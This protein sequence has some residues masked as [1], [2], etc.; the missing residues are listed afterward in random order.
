MIH[1]I[2]RF[3]SCTLDELIRV[4]SEEPKTK[5]LG[6]TKL[7]L[8]PAPEPEEPGPRCK[9]ICCKSVRRWWPSNP[10][11]WY[12]TTCK[13]VCRRAKGHR[14]L[15]SCLGTAHELYPDEDSIEMIRRITTL[16]YENGEVDHIADPPL[17]GGLPAWTKTK[18]W[19]GQTVFCFEEKPKLKTQKDSAELQQ[20]A[21][22]PDPAEEFN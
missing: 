16:T 12:R 17:N 18:P 6:E 21:V 14:D 10:G 9:S 3:S 8:R 1:K 7:Y 13:D 20:E 5:W 15:C 11:Y 4:S 2:P 22:D 19:C